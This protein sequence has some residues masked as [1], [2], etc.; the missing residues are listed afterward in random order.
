MRKSLLFDFWVVVGL[1]LCSI[2]LILLFRVRPLTSAI[3]FFVFPAIYLFLRKKKPIKRV[4]TG[5]ILIG[6]GIGFIFNVIL[7]FNNAWNELSSQLVFNYRLFGFWPA[8]EPIWF[9]LWALFI[10]VFYEHFYERETRGKIS[11]RFKY[12]AFPIFLIFVFVFTALANH[13]NSFHLPYAYFLLALPAI[14][15]V[16]YVLR[17]YPKL[18][19]KF[20]KTGIFFFFLFFIYELTAVKLGQW[21]FSGQYI[22]WVELIGLKFPLEELFFW[23]ILSSFAVLSLY[24]GFVDDSK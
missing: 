1:I 20:F 11:N 17:Y 9:F 3:F 6:V 22:G 21:Y 12:V 15:P 18:S 24:E 2:P 19:L 23:M 13:C 5:S 14:I 10:I 4:L 16:G 8:D 7:S